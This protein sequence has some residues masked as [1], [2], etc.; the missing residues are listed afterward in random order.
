MFFFFFCPSLFFLLVALSRSP[1]MGAC[2][3]K[4]PTV[5]R[6]SAAVGVLGCY[7]AGKF[8][9][10]YVDTEK[11]THWNA[12]VDVLVS[13]F[14]GSTTSAP[15]PIMSWVYTGTSQLGPLASAPNEQRVSWFKY[16]MGF[17]ALICQ[18]RGG[19]YALVDKETGKVV[20]AA[21]VIPPG[22]RRMNQMSL[23]EMI[24]IDGKLKRPKKDKALDGKWIA[25]NSYLTK[26]M[27]STH[28]EL[29]PG[30]HLYVLV[31]GSDP[32]AQG[33][34]AGSALMGF[35][36]KL[37]DA[38]GVPMYLESGAEKGPGFF[39]KKGGF[40]QSKRVTLS[41]GK[42]ENFDANGGL[43]AMVRPAR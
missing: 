23:R 29:A 17:S 33:T 24:A 36:H 11:H 18:G 40:E 12:T 30:D 16:N 13:A 41:H 22:A 6:S 31:F 4:M 5:V 35:L 28:T 3:G 26:T 2:L 7:D 39:A 1:P 19:L 38:D 42:A 14:C 10:H 32:A 15:C 25:R 34:G 20:S 27:S 43:V 8:E 9:V 21:G 37:A